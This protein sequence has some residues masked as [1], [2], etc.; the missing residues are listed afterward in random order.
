MENETLFNEEEEPPGPSTGLV[1]VKNNVSDFLLFKE[2]VSLYPIKKSQIEFYSL[3]KIHHDHVFSEPDIIPTL[4]AWNGLIGIGSC[5][6]PSG[7]LTPCLKY[8]IFRI[9]SVR[10]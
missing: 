3:L 9:M 2:D 6:T 10:R 8:L 7:T 1:N 4:P 5:V